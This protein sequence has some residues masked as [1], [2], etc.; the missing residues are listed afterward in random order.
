MKKYYSFETMF[1]SLKNELA[2]FLKENGIYYELSG[3]TASYHFEILLD[4]DET[5]KVNDWLDEHT[6]WYKRI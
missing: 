6:I 3:T 5:Q 2:K 4:S 1:T